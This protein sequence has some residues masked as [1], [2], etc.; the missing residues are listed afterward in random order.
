MRIK[1]KEYHPL[2]NA[3]ENTANQNTGKFL[4]T[5]QCFFKNMFHWNLLKILTSRPFG[6]TGKPLY[7]QLYYIQLSHHVLRVC[8]IDC[9]G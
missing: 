1:S 3:L 6:N 7:I 8:C 2:N 9:V 4:E 5:T